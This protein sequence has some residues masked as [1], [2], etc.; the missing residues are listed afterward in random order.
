MCASFGSVG[1]K[2]AAFRIRSTGCLVCRSEVDLVSYAAEILVRAVL[3]Q[4]LFGRDWRSDGIGVARAALG[5]GFT[6]G[7]SI[8]P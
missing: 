1:V 5:V 7:D 3:R 8:L 6:V 4:L 2:P